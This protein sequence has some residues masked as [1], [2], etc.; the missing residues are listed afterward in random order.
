[1]T[2]AYIHDARNELDIAFALLG[3]AL[4]ALDALTRRGT[5]DPEDLEALRTG[6]SIARN[7]VESGRDLLQPEPKGFTT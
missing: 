3:L 2:A 1:M 6:I 7:C 5:T 4:G